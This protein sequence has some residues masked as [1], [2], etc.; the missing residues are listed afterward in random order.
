MKIEFRMKNK[1]EIEIVGIEGKQRKV[2]GGIFTPS[3]SGGIYPNSIQVCGFDNA[4]QLWGCG[5]FGRYKGTL[6]E[7]TLFGKVDK[8]HYE[9]LKDIQLE[10]SMES[11]PHGIEGTDGRCLKCYNIPC[12]C[13][14]KNPNSNPYSIRREPECVMQERIKGLK[15]RKSRTPP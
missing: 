10:Y 6:K 13:D 7:S 5:I 12:T 11:E 3:G 15:R 14:N 4:F 1:Q 9:Q 2:I 8:K